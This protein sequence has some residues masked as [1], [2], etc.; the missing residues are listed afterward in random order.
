MLAMISVGCR[1]GGAARPGTASLALPFAGESTKQSAKESARASVAE[2]NDDGTGGSDGGIQLTAGEDVAGDGVGTAVR[3]VPAT[4]AG[5]STSPLPS[6][7][8]SLPQSVALA[9]EQ[10]PD[11]IALRQ[12]ENVGSAALGVAQTYPF[13]PFVQIQA[14]PY[15]D[16][17][18]AGPGTT[19]HYVLL[20]QTIQ[21][22]HQQQFREEGAASALNSTRWNIHQAELQNVAQTERLYFNLLYQ[23]GLL[24][25]ASASHEN[26]QRLLRTIE[27]QLDAGQATAAD[28]A[29]VRMDAR[30]TGQQARLAKAN[31]E[32]ALR[33][34]KRQLGFPPD[35]ATAFEGD[36]RLFKWKIPVPGGEDP[37]RPSG[38]SL[39]L[40]T[41]GTL[42]WMTSRG[43]ARPDVVAAQSD[44]EAARAALCLASASRTPDLQVGPYY[45]RTADGTS[46]LGF[47][48]QMDLPVV[49]SGRPLEQQ[50]SAELTQ[51]L[52]AWQQLR[53]RA[54]L[55][56]QA[57][58][59]RYELALAALAEDSPGGATD[60][61]G[62]LQSLEQQFLAGEVD[63]V[64]VVQARASIIQNQ[65][66]QLD[67]LNEV[68]QSAAN[69]TATAGVAMDEVLE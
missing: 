18:S 34:L 21:L 25:L 2:R 58:W 28:A 51:R 62:E 49:N 47:R 50:R 1:S 55:E 15:Q 38:D 4:V 9:L 24:E 20:M 11:L 32:T 41:G 56:A 42:S 45:Q 61:P 17:P 10:N 23:R 13:N 6:Q 8:L 43:A 67:L 26:N 16:R 27:K 69:L 19:Y 31:H 39:R 12:S 7:S 48:A 60:L 66:V 64:R 22:A 35:D 59:K 63:V 46:F 37:A 14:T 53:R 5:S 36:L 3:A 30:A 68:A 57:A 40:D 52:T 54:E 65:R 29:I 44:M 33:D